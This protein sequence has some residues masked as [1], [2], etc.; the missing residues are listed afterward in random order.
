[1]ELTQEQIY[2]AL[3]QGG[4]GR[5]GKGKYWAIIDGKEYT[6]SKME[7]L[8]LTHIIKST[9]EIINGK[10]YGVK[11]DKFRNEGVYKKMISDP[12][13]DDVIKDLGGD[14]SDL[15]EARSNI[16]SYREII[17]DSVNYSASNDKTDED[18]KK[19]KTNIKAIYS[20]WIAEVVKRKY[21]NSSISDASKILKA[22]IDEEISN[23]PYES[24][25]GF[26]E[27][28]FAHIDNMING[29]ALGELKPKHIRYIMENFEYSDEQKN[30]AMLFLE[31]L[32][33]SLAATYQDT[34]RFIEGFISLCG[35]YG[36]YSRGEEILQ[37]FEDSYH[38]AHLGEPKSSR[39]VIK[40]IAKITSDDG[41]RQTLCDESLVCLYALGYKTVTVDELEKRGVNTRT[42]IDGFKNGKIDKIC[43]LNLIEKRNLPKGVILDSDTLFDLYSPFVIDYSKMVI[44]L[45]QEMKDV[46][47]DINKCL[48]GREVLDL[49]KRGHINSEKLIEVYE[50][51]EQI[52]QGSILGL[53]EASFDDVFAPNVELFYF[54]NNA[55]EVIKMLKNEAYSERFKDMYF[56]LRTSMLGRDEDKD[57]ENQR[58]ILE[59]FFKDKKDRPTEDL[60]LLVYEGIIDLDVLPNFITLEGLID[61]AEKLQIPMSDLLSKQYIHLNQ[62]SQSQLLNLYNDPNIERAKILPL[63]EAATIEEMYMD[64]NIEISE[65]FSGLSD[66]NI[67]RDIVFG[68]MSHEEIREYLRTR[69]ADPS[70]ILEA[71]MKGYLPYKDLMSI[72]IENTSGEKDKKDKNGKNIYGY[73]ITRNDIE[74]YIDNLTLPTEPDKREEYLKHLEELFINEVLSYDDVLEKLHN[75][76]KITNDEYNRLFDVQYEIAIR[77]LSKINSI[78]NGAFPM[79]TPTGPITPPLPGPKKQNVPVIDP[80]YIENL[81]NVLSVGKNGTPDMKRI[82]ILDGALKGYTLVVLNNMKVGILEKIDQD[83]KTNDA[84]YVLPVIYARELSEKENKS[85]LRALKGDR[86]VIVV[87]HVR[88][89]G[90]NLREAIGDMQ[91]QQKISKNNPDITWAKDKSDPQRE[92]EIK[93]AKKEIEDSYDRNLPLR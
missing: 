5:E 70:S 10:E 71:Y 11:R 34:S 22:I 51:Q 80:I 72:G 37:V 90:Q 87:N 46:F 17:A 92:Q 69:E 68:L 50:Q 39:N 76:G 73:G 93:D 1:M 85:G 62:L 19:S 58:F 8:T 91:K 24:F 38:L 77:E 9:A 59:K 2:N 4:I 86:H 66:G 84:T 30:N 67:H 15:Y 25:K 64:G 32:Y 61:V 75:T 20:Y 74:N 42:I 36:L 43:L 89:Y 56:S 78:V 49:V 33:R 65:I 55:E 44:N 23:P 82:E 6:F 63:L 29:I 31:K 79:G 54:F 88:N 60:A 27:E 28:D 26:L 41:F 3:L 12:I 47:T 13:V 16:R 7:T 18:Y 53:G 35:K 48:T 21:A 45:P 14:W 40:D 83:G 81:L 57:K 52:L